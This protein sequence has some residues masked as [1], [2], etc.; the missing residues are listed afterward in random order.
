[1]QTC[2]CTNRFYVHERVYDAFAEKLSAA[3]SQLKIGHGTDLG[4]TLGPLINEA[5]VKKVESHIA[6]ALAKGA[7]IVTGGKRHALGRGFFEPTV[8]TGVNPDME[9]AQE[10]TFGPLAPLFRFSSDEEVVRLA[11]DTQF[12]LA[13]YFY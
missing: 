13:A 1:G 10:E 6:D 9:V 4:V 12:G 7:S 3:V 2:V 11:N 8:M 5:A